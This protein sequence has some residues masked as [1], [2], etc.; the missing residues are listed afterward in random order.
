V[1]MPKPYEVCSTNTGYIKN[2]SY[3]KWD[4]YVLRKSN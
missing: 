4:Y 1:S 2:S 3:T